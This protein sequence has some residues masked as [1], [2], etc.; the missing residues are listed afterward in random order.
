MKL[1]I[2]LFA[3]AR[4]IIEKDEIEIELEIEQT[5]Q[6]HVTNKAKIFGKIEENFQSLAPIL[7]V[8]N[9]AHNH[10]SYNGS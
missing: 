8:C 3:E 6:G 1:K 10:V 5:N 2:L 7:E 9:L 4:E